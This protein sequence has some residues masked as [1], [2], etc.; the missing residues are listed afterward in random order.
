M[1]KAY[2]PKCQKLDIFGNGVYNKH[3]KMWGLYG[4]SNIIFNDDE[5]N[6]R[7][8]ELQNSGRNVHICSTLEKYVS[9]I[10]I[11]GYKYNGEIKW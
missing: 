8:C 2:W 9:K 11:D 4:I 3:I 5:I 1:S 7:T 6:R 10:Y